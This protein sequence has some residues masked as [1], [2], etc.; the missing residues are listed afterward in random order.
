[1]LTTVCN[2]GWATNTT[3]SS[4]CRAT[5]FF[6]ISAQPHFNRDWRWM[7]HFH[8]RNPWGKESTRI[9]KMENMRQCFAM[10]TVPSRAFLGFEWTQWRFGTVAMS[11]WREHNRN[12]GAN[13]DTSDRL[14]VRISCIESVQDSVKNKTWQTIFLRDLDFNYHFTNR[15]SVEWVLLA[16][17]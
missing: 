15:R 11:F 2:M 3:D 6:N 9:S 8:S 1:M 16:L 13:R 14:H 12:C 4:N 10:K 7:F 17:Q 5:I